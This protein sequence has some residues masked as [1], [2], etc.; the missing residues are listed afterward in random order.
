MAKYQRQASAKA[1][2]STPTTSKS[3]S[4]QFSHQQSTQP[5][6]EDEEVLLIG[7]ETS[8]S[9]NSYFFIPISTEYIDARRMFYWSSLAEMDFINPSKTF[10][11]GRIIPFLRN[12]A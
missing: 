7:L 12:D 3:F 5:Q 1:S 2:V 9:L 11:L 10:E 4:K 8:V 6:Q